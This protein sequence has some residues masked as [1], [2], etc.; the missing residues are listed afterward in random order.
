MNWLK[1]Y[2]L[3]TSL[4]EAAT[5]LAAPGSAIIGG[6]SRLVA[7]KPEA[8]H[9]L[10]DLMPLG[11]DRIERRNGG[12]VLGAR[13][14]MEDLVQ[15]DDFGGLL[16]QALLSMTHSPN[17]RNQMTVAG[18]TAWPR[19]L[20]EWQV[21]LLALDASIRRHDR[22]PAAADEY[23]ADEK[24]EGIITAVAFPDRTGWRFG[25][26]RIAPAEGARPL[27]VLAAGA[28]LDGKRIADL[29][30]AAGNLALRPQRLHELEQR[31]QGAAPEDLAD[32]ALAPGDKD[33]IRVEDGPGAAATSKWSWLQTLVGR[34]LASL[35]ADSNP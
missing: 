23:F 12:L 8:I 14:R 35:R 1:E 29:R 3:A 10:I 2:E 32:F 15:R 9:R 33:G 17:M 30:L 21:A 22:D 28:R 13:V 5:L 34:F 7:A 6:G 26:D 16:K 20:N 4:D 11:L 31:L 25:F 19:H 24:R 27:L 18:E